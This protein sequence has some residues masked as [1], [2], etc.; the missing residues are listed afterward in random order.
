MNL[1]EKIPEAARLIDLDS[2]PRHVAIIMDGNG[3]G[4]GARCRA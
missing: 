3:L 2:L 1:F 4:K